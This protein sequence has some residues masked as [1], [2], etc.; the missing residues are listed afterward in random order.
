MA[1]ERLAPDAILSSTALS[2]AVTAVQDDPD[3]PDGSWLTADT[4]GATACRVSFPSPSGNPAAGA[5]LQA[6]RAQ[7]RVNSGGGNAVS[8]SLDLYEN[9][10]AIA[11]LATG[12]ASG[13]AEVIAGAWNASALGTAD[14]SLVECG[15]SQTGGHTGKG[16][17]RRYLEIGAVEWNAEYTEAVPNHALGAATGIDAGA[18]D[19]GS[20]ALSQVHGLSSGE[21]AAGAPLLG[22]AVIGQ[23]HDIAAVGI[24]A[25]G[26]TLGSPTASEGSTSSSLTASGLTAGAPTLGTPSTGSSHALTASGA[27]TGS[28][29]LGGPSLAQVHAMLAGSLITAAPV[30]GRPSDG[31]TSGR[32]LANGHHRSTK[33]RLAVGFGL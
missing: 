5:G 10:V 14:G 26:P 25:G 33:M 7:I 1:A 31:S 27:V 29:S 9:G 15:L 22:A 20:P 17:D 12:T 24:D 19:I 4:S 32:R 3:S 28:V 13:P 2:G 16:T 6:F 21:L 18:P 8:W 23:R 11:T 30:L